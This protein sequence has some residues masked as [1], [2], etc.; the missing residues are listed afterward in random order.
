MLLYSKDSK[1]YWTLSSLFPTY[2]CQ[3]ENR[4]SNFFFS[5]ASLVT[6]PAFSLSSSRRSSIGHEDKPKIVINRDPFE[7]AT[8]THLD[9]ASKKYSTT[10]LPRNF[11]LQTKSSY[12]TRRDPASTASTSPLPP[13]MEDRKPSK[14]DLFVT[15]AV[16]VFSRTRSTVW[17]SEIVHP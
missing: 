3:I 7:E 4:I 1:I 15:F 12:E 11:S 8:Q 6:S 13:Q 2:L 9:Y 17:K 5:R 10:S 14:C 16:Y